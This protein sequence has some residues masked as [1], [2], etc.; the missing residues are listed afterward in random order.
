MADE[1]PEAACFYMDDLLT[2]ADSVEAAI[3]LQQDIHNVLASGQFPLRK[4]ISNSSE[5]LATL[6]SSLIET[7]S[8]HF[9]ENSEMATLLGLVWMPHS[10]VMGIKFNG[11]TIGA[12]T[13]LTKRVMLS[14]TSQIFDPLGLLAPFVVWFKV[15]LQSLWKEQLGWDDPVP[16]SISDP[17]CVLLFELPRVKEFAIRPAYT[18]Q[19][20][21]VRRKLFGFCDASVNAYSAVVYLRTVNF[22][23]QCDSYIVCAKTRVAPLK[24]LTIHRLELMAA[25]LLSKLITQISSYLRIHPENVFCFSDSQVTLCWLSKAPE[26]WQVFVANRV[27][28]IQAV[29]PISHWAYIRTHDNPAYLPSRGITIEKLLN[30]TL[31]LQGPSFLANPAGFECWKSDAA[32]VNTSVLEMRQSKV[33]LATTKVHTTTIF[34]RF[35]PFLRLRA[36]VDWLLRF[37]ENVH[38]QAK[39][40]IKRKLA[41]PFCGEPCQALSMIELLSL[42]FAIPN[43]WR[44]RTSLLLFPRGSLLVVVAPSTHYSRSL[45]PR[46]YCALLGV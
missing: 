36:V 31:W 43:S 13:I 1:K 37:T 5:L 17:F 28:V 15:L 24:S 40:D 46:G 25:Q 39:S 21:V 35:S 7:L 14:L 42:F 34:D 3:Q 2:G 45:M 23:D 38:S 19:S 20:G 33:C 6:D 18:V 11:E 27:R 32:N 30:S 4:Y 41:F 9:F 8:I 16:S 29:L 44:I 26:N 22:E 12:E 10:D